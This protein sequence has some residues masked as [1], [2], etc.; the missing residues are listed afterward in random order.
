MTPPDTFDNTSP[1]DLP[2]PLPAPAPGDAP[3]PGNAPAAGDGPGA[4]PAGETTSPPLLEM[5]TRPAVASQAKPRRARAADGH[6][7]PVAPAGGGAVPGGS[8][9]MRTWYS[10]AELAAEMG[11]HV[12]R[13]LRWISAGDL[14]A[15]NIGGIARS[16]RPEWRIAAGK[17]REFVRRRSSL[18]RVPAAF[19]EDP[20]DQGR[21]VT[22]RRTACRVKRYGGQ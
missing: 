12:G 1:T 10:P 14:E 17:I 7:V 3:A 20:E 2:G 5:P 22:P 6:A 11:V 13:V 19:L 21:A 16:R 4:E 18:G 8:G 9:G 15:V